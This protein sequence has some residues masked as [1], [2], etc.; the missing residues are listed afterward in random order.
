MVRLFVQELTRSRGSAQDASCLRTTSLSFCCQNPHC[1]RHGQRDAGNL[2]VCDHF[3]K[4]NHR[5]LASHR[6]PGPVLRV[7][8]EPRC[9]T[10]SSHTRKSWQSSRISPMAGGV[11]Q[12]RPAGGGQQGYRH[13]VGPAGRRACQRHPRRAGGLFPPR[14]AKSSSMRSGP[15]SARK[16]RTAIP[17]TPTTISAAIIGT[18]VAFDPEHKLVLAVVPAARVEE[19][20]YA[21]VAAVKTAGGRFATA[22]DD[23][24]RV[25]GLRHGD[26]GGLPVSQRPLRHNANRDVLASCPIAGCRTTW[27]T[28]PCIRSER[29]TASSPWTRGKSS[30]RGRPWRTFSP[31]RR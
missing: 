5:L 29:T 27:S 26:R 19:N 17:P 28:R 3:G 10:P 31:S 16:R 1:P 18:S 8:R 23:Q 12:N 24:R 7:Q 22:V 30:A 2:S 9:S 4:A 6:L 14:P 15:S 20:A 13:A 21:I 25:P 11:R